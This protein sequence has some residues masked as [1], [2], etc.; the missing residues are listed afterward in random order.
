MTGANFNL[1]HGFGGLP[2]PKVQIYAPNG[3]VNVY[4]A[5]ASAASAGVHTLDARRRV[6]VTWPGLSAEVLNRFD[7]YRPKVELLRYQPRKKTD[8]GARNAGAKTA[9][10][11]H[12]SHGPLIGSGSFTHGGEHSG[13]SND[14][15][16]LRETEWDILAGGGYADVTQ[17]IL[18]FMDYTEIRY[19]DTTSKIVTEKM[20]TAAARMFRNS[21]VGR[22]F[23]YSG[24][25]GAGFFRFRLSI[26]D[27][28]DARLKRIHGPLSDVITCSNAVFPFR[29]EGVDGGG[30]PMASINPFFVSDAVQFWIGPDRSMGQN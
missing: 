22:V 13:A 12:P 11:V 28:A 18:G 16:Q 20:V 26:R 17:G 3:A 21:N 1:P 10:Y 19:R 15:Q 5:E 27:L 4:C 24:R 9:G 30:Y 23:P 25:F 29:S 6:K 7:L 8:S 2:A 14:V